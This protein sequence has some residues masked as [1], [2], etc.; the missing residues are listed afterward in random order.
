M[1]ATRWR[2]THV[3]VRERSKRPLF[4]D[5]KV[6]ARPRGWMEKELDKA[7]S[8]APFSFFCHFHVCD[9]HVC[10]HICVCVGA[11][12]LPVILLLLFQH[13]PQNLLPLFVPLSRAGT[14]PGYWC[15]CS[16]QAKGSPS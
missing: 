15:Y 2:T 5:R 3:S 14:C 12:A 9:L 1:N 16:Q 10:M 4:L 7:N 11:G 8:K 6:S 13:L